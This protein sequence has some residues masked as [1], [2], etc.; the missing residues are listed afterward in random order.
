VYFGEMEDGST[1]TAKGRGIKIFATKK[2]LVGYYE[3]DKM[4]GQARDVNYDGD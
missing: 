1:T 3:N 2:V 4:N